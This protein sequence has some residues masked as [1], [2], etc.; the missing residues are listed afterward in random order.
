MN[1]RPST[2]AT[3]DD[4]WTWLSSSQ[5]GARLRQAFWSAIISLLLV[6]LAAAATLPP[7]PLAVPL[8]AVLLGGS[9]WLVRTLWTRA[10]CAVAVSALGLGVRGGLDVAQIAWPAVEGVFG[11]PVGQRLRIVVAARGARHETAATFGREATLDW[12]AACAE[13]AERRRLR[14]EPVEGMAGF[15]TR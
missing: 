11:V 9:A 13:H 3:T 4:G 2:V 15:R 14:P 1:L 7:R 5:R 12:L 8:V 10:H 6:A